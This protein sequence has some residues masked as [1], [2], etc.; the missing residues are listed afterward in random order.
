MTRTKQIYYNTVFGAIGGLIAWL[1]VGL[2]QTG[3]WNL[4]AAVIFIG[5][6]TGLFIGGAVGM[7]EGVMVKKSATRAILGLVLGGIAGLIS[8]FIGLLIGQIGFLLT[9]GGFVGR[10]LGWT[11][12]GFFLGAGL[13]IVNLK[14]KRAFYGLIGGTLAGLIG[15]IIYEGVT[16]LFLQQSDT[17][18]VF[19]GA[20]GLILIGASL[21]GITALSVEVIERVVG[22]GVLVVRSGRREGMEVSVTDAVTLGSYDGCEVYLPGDP[23]IAKEHAQVV[24]R[25]KTFVVKDLNSPSGTFVNNSRLSSGGESQSLQSGSQIRLGN[26]VIEFK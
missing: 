11:A 18:Q 2:L 23:Q 21:G 9:D 17:A 26:T 8:G 20:L 3:D 7:V 25:G 16:Q 15:G 24:K 19:L 14:L 1:L 4:W 10:A 12:F 5:A 13:S 6:G 22:R